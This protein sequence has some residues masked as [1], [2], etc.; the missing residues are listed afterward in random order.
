MSPALARTSL[1]LSFPTCRMATRVPTSW[2][3]LGI[4]YDFPATHIEGLLGL[5]GWRSGYSLGISHP[6]WK[7]C[8]RGTGKVG[9]RGR[10]WGVEVTAEM[11][12]LFT[13]TIPL[14]FCTLDVL[15]VPASLAVRWAISL[16]TGHRS[17]GK[18]L[19]TPCPRGLGFC[20]P[21]S[22]NSST[23][24]SLLLHHTPGH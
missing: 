4:A 9:E 21:A 8:P 20:Q 22:P 1:K 7:S 23:E 2:G 3:C 14:S 12:Q 19:E 13:Q 10:A 5:N 11:G 15:D 24:L 17:A 6:C 16:R 18:T